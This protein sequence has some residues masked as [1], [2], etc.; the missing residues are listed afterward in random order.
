MAAV[1]V[2]QQLAA[3]ADAAA[4][5]VELSNGCICCTLRGDLFTELANLARI[6]GIEHIVIESSGISEPR[7]IVDLY[8]ERFPAGAAPAVAVVADEAGLVVSPGGFPEAGSEAGVGATTTAPPAPQDFHLDCLATVVDAEKFLECFA[9]RMRVGENDAMRTVEGAVAEDQRLLAELLVEQVECATL[10]I[11]NKAD[12][13]L[14]DDLLRL[15]ELVASMNAHAR[16]EV[17][18]FGV[19]PLEL[20]LATGGYASLRSSLAATGAASSSAPVHAA[21][22]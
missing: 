4:P 7:A 14:H 16:I 18:T 17:A 21:L 2:D 12:L 13:V 22:L 20:V 3:G 5:M 8:E 9:S 6:P 1:N 15:Q 11:I 19:V 10:V